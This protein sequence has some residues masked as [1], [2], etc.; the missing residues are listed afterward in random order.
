MTLLE[1]PVL[2]TLISALL[3]FLAGLVWYHPKV[4]GD[5]WMK[6]RGEDTNSFEIKNK[7]AFLS[8]ML[9]LLTACF[10]SFMV[11]IIEIDQ[12]EQMQQIPTF[13]AFSC[14]LWV[15]F[16]MPPLLMGALYTGYAFEAVAIDAAYQLAGYYI[17][18]LVHIGFLFLL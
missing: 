7:K 17:M 10:Y 11:M 15:A 3:A 8:L 1:F 14:L 5:K 2:Q 13:F 9:W 4:L 6:A 16:A 12:I 18:A